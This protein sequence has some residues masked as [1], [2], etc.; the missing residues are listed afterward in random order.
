MLFLGSILWE[1]AVQQARVNEL[2]FALLGRELPLTFMCIP[3]RLVSLFEVQKAAMMGSLRKEAHNPSAQER[4]L[5]NL[6]H[7]QDLG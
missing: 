3:I 6:S 1:F 2:V 5:R 7:Y 4:A